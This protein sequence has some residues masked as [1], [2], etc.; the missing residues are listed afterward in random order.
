LLRVSFEE[1]A[2]WAIIQSVCNE[3]Q[4]LAPQAI[5]IKRDNSKPIINLSTTISMQKDFNL[6]KD[7]KYE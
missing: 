6:Y 7:E 3:R 4:K 2:C 1:D 5:D